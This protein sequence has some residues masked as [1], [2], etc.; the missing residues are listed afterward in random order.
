MD[1]GANNPDTFYETPHVDRLAQEGMRFTNGYAANPVCSPTRYS[2]MTGRYPSRVD[3]TN[4]FSGRR[5]GRFREA[6]LNDRMPI[7]EITLAEALRAAGYRTAFLGKWHL[8][9]SEEYWP[10]A[11]GF[12][13][14]VGGHD[15]GSPPGGYFAPYRNPKLTDG[16][17][18]EHLTARLTDEALKIL[19]QFRDEPFL[20]YLSFYTVHTPLQA[21]QDLIEKYRRKAAATEG[22]PEFADEEQVWPVDQPRRVRSLQR[23]ATYAAMVEDDGH[24]RGTRTRPTAGAGIGRQYGG[25]LH[26]RQRRPLDVRRLTHLQSAAARRQRLAVRGWN[27]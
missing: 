16:P 14:N 13:I 25:L 12:Q 23:H 7:E 27:P 3:A 1:I 4:W 18:G 26:V 5:E 2:I 24:Q 8:G 9:P 11:Q 17:K 15:R 20:L 19:Q 10:E 22:Q 6:P 21:P